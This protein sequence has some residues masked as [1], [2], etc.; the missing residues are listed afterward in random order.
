MVTNA[1]IGRTQAPTPAEVGAA[2]GKAKARWDRLLARLQPHCDGS[3]WG[4]SGK[5]HGW[6]LRMLRG[7]RVIVYLTP[8]AGEFMASFALGDK[9]MTAARAAGLPPAV[10]AVLDGARRYA[11][12]NAVRLE[13]K[14]AADVDAVA[15]LARIKIEH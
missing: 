15:A 11:E 10:V 8:G 6:A 9:A 7:D 13:V 3:A 14:T 1:F 2:L 12:G 5:K 4:S